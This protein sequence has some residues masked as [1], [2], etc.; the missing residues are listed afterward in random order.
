MKNHIS[1]GIYAGFVATIVLSVLMVLKSLLHMLP[2]MNAIKMLASMAHGYL[3]I[4]MSPTI[5]WVLHFAIGSLLWGILFAWLYRRLPG[6][7]ASIKGILFGTFAWLIMMIVVMPMAGAGLFG[8]HLG[9]GAPVATLVLH[10]IY[11]AVLGVVYG[12][13]ISSGLMTSHTH[14]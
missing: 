7:A 8:L 13:L 1:K 4:P 9:L 14:A 5:G 3:G 2:K 6:Q 10:W 12:K 11:G